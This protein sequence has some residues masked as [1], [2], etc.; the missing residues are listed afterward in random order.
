[1][2]SYGSNMAPSLKRHAPQ[3]SSSIP[4]PSPLHTHSP[5]TPLCYTVSPKIGQGFKAFL[6][7]AWAHVGP[8]WLKIALKH[9]FEHPKWCGNHFGKNHFRPHSDPPATP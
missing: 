2:C 4:H 8:R 7:L 9:L 5:R 3:H 6:E 1:M